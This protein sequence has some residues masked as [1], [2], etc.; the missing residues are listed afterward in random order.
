M[1]NGVSGNL[2]IDRIVEFR[3]FWDS[4]F[5]ESSFY[6]QTIILIY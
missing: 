3:V 1:L 5:S 4:D 6:I 2:I